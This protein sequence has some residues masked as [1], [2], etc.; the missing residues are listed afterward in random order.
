MIQLSKLS[1]VKVTRP[2]Y[3]FTLDGG[4]FQSFRV[5]KPVGNRGS[6]VSRLGMGEEDAQHGI[7]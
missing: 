5:A 7:C 6:K 2:S 3:L 4:V 1:G